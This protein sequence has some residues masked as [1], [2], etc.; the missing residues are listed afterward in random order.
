MNREPNQN[1]NHPGQ[2]EQEVRVVYR[3]DWAEQTAADRKRERRGA[4]R[5]AV[6][7][8]C[9]MAAALLLCVGMLAGVM[10]VQGR[11]SASPAAVGASAVQ[12]AAEKVTPATVLI[13][14]TGDKKGGTG[15]G[16]FIRSDGYIVTNYHVI[17]GAKSIRVYRYGEETVSIEAEL[18]GGSEIDDVA[19]IRIKKTNCPVV[20]IGDSDAVRV[21]D[22][23]IAIGNPGGTL[24]PFSTTQG[25]ISAV[26]RSISVGDS[27]VALGEMDMIQTDAAV[28]PGNSGGP[29][30]NDRGEVIGIVTRKTSVSEG[31]IFEGIGY[32]IPINTAMKLVNSILANGGNPDASSS[33]RV[34]PT[35]GIQCSSI[36][37]GEAFSYQEEDY[38][39]QADGVLVSSVTPGGAAV[40]K[41]HPG[42]LIVAADGTPTLD[43]KTMI[44]MLYHYEIGSEIVLT[45]YPLGEDATVEVTIVLGVAAD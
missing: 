28:N 45:V 6:V 22:T 9:V 43:T 33:V 39:A 41:L 29:L 31:T 10:A 3:W 16:F 21:G 42:D 36:A 14:V 35:I 25:I 23:A 19:V 15:T 2:P 18:I 8:A 27:T 20:T 37:K 30:C 17:D 38:F 26:S 5:G 44:E 7:F 32:A 12:K 1:Q 11:N 4:K 40:G 13:S 34:R 24:A